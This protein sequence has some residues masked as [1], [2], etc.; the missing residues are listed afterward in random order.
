MKTHH[1]LVSGLCDHNN[2]DFWNVNKYI[3]PSIRTI[4]YEIICLS[5]TQAYVITTEVERNIVYCVFNSHFR[6]CNVWAR[7]GLIFA[8][9]LLTCDEKK[10]SM[11]IEHTESN[12]NSNDIFIII[13]T[14]C[15]T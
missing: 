14:L 2:V 8:F 15:V 10:L 11:N 9:P 6:V 12:S 4:D 13:S 1:S 5:N 7:V 3:S